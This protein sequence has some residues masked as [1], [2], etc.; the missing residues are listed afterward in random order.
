[1]ANVAFRINVSVE[2]DGQG[3]HA[4]DVTVV[5]AID[6]QRFLLTVAYPAMK[7]DVGVA[8]DGHRDFAPAD[9]VERAAHNFMLKGAKLGMWH[10]DGHDD[11]AEVVESYIWRAD[12]W[13]VKAEDGSTQTI[14]PGDW[15]VGSIL[16]EESWAMYKSGTIGGVSPQGRAQRKIPSADSLAQ[17]RS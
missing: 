9:V 7:A 13:V 3:P 6:E 15:L 16:S 11:C 10:E 5:K 2:P 8:Q 17:L 12:P 4:A 1:M 14:M